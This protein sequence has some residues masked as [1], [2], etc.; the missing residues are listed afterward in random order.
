MRM[1]GLRI[2][3]LLKRLLIAYVLI[4]LIMWAFQRELM[5]L[6]TTDIQSPEAYGITGF[7]PLRLTSKDGTPISAWFRT[8]QAGFPT[9]LYFHGNGGNLASRAHYFHLLASAGFGVL[10][11][12]YRGY[13][14]SEGNPSEEGFYQDARATVE[15]ALAKAALPANQIILYGESIGTGVAVQMAS[16]YP[17]AA[18]VLHSP[19]TSIEDIAKDSYPWLPVHYL[20]KD[21]FD[22]LSKLAD[23][24]EPLLLFHGEQDTIV[25]VAL[26]KELFAHA[27]EPKEALYFP[28]GGHNDLPL[29]E[30][31]RALIA[32]SKKQGVIEVRK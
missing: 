9:L 29:E 22:S 32:F 1:Y 15:Y 31:T 4:C 11:L 14:A 21:R 2:V 19:F 5:Y 23:V 30:L 28:D 27:R 16:E 7:D 18:L 25:P 17:A 3:A 26:G 13:G 6:P 10:A 12:D 20:L 24:S 8:A